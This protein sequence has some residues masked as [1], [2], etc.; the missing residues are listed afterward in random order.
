[1]PGMM[2]Q[3]NRAPKESAASRKTSEARGAV[4]GNQALLR[5]L[6][7]KLTIGAV[8]DPLEHE[9]DAMAKQVMRMPDPALSLRA[10]PPRIS[11]TCTA[12][13]EE[14]KLHAKPDRGTPQRGAAIPSDGA[15]APGSVEQALRS[16]AQT[17]DPMTRGFFEARF[18]ADFSRVQIHSGERAARSAQDVGARAYAVG[19]HIV[20]GA[21]HF[22]P[23]SRDG[24]ELLA[25]EL[26]HVVQQTGPHLRRAGF[27]YGHANSC[28]DDPHLKFIWPG[29][30]LASDDVA[31]AIKATDGTPTAP[32]AA[33]LLQFFGD[34]GKDPANVRKIHDNFVAIS[35]ALTQHY[36][37]H[38]SK[39]GDTSDSAA[40]TCNGN[41]AKTSQ[42]GERDITLC[43]DDLSKWSVPWAAWL[44]IHE[45]THR[46]LGF[47]MD[48]F[49]AGSL[50]HCSIPANTNPFPRSTAT[51]LGTPDC[52]A[53]FAMAAGGAAAAAAAGPTPAPAPTQAPGG[54]TPDAGTQVQRSPIDGASATVLRRDLATPPPAAPAAPQPDLTPAQIQDAI[55]YNAQYYDAANTKLIQGILGGPVTGRWTTANIQAIAATQEQYGLKKDGKVGP[56]TFKF[57]TQEQNAEGAG[58]DTASCLTAFR[59][60]TFPL[61]TNATPGPGGT[62]NIRG[63]HTIEARF[64]D[65]CTCGEFRYRQFIGGV[66]T[67]SRHGAIQNF[68]PQ[69]THIPGGLPVA[70]REDG[71]TQ[72]PAAP[73]Y[74]DRAH[75]G[76]GPSGADCPEDRYT[77]ADG[78]AD[79]A[80]GCVYHAEDFPSLSVTGL[81]TGDTV[82]VQIQFRGEIERNG[83][84]VAT[85][86]W[87]D[88]D[89]TVVTP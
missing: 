34:D 24:Q 54:N 85:R 18:G 60:I 55:N 49:Q 35:N 33:L 43:F 12:C 73:T 25:H 30:Q 16:P 42:K 56:D 89:T 66:A 3:T 39:M 61:Q 44:I 5:Q 64:S 83:R 50:D 36:M 7:R 38:C 32:V 17:L 71:K 75:A 52:Y 11:R 23:H 46:A 74:G 58:T 77:D 21:G 13:E 4:A 57:I 26:T 62:T 70:T 15:A 65:R 14:G 53:C 22:S 48:P 10:G 87:T 6:Q 80:S 45:N 31:A 47:W 19:D 27:Q 41:N 28:K 63:H 68:A 2:V 29:Q 88:I 69:F 72:C 81:A 40:E 1:M 76:H 78:T 8:D 82:D 20:F 86:N 67:A 37:Y 51:C 84:T 79:Q 9:A 59:F